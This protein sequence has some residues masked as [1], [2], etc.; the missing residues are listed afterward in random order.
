M[1]IT[2]KK[3]KYNLYKKT[4]KNKIQLKKRIIKSFKKK[5]IR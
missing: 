1:Q 2:L 3:D 4:R 5:K